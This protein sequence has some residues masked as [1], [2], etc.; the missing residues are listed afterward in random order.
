M[1]FI[2]QAIP[3]WAD[4]T[5]NPKDDTRSSNQISTSY[6]SD[7]FLFLDTNANQM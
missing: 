5:W 7:L 1:L 3:T 2:P 4:I 6:E